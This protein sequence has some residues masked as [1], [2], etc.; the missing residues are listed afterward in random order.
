MRTALSRIKR[1]LTGQTGQGAKTK[2]TEAD[3]SQRAHFQW[4]NMG[5]LKEKIKPRSYKETIKVGICI[6]LL[7]FYGVIYN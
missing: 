2:K 6:Q 5:F 1:D 7:T 4:N 3:L